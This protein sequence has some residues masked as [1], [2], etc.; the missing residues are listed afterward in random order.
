ML[1]DLLESGNCFKLVCGAGNEDANEV[2]NLIKIY[3]KAGCKF[4]DIN[5]SVE[6]L[7]TAK[8]TLKGDGY[9][10]VSIGIKGDPHIDK[11]IVDNEKCDKCNMCDCEAVFDT[12]KCIGC[13]K[14]VTRC[15]KNAI[16]LVPQEKNLEEIIPPLIKIGV[17]C[18]ELH[19]DS[20]NDRAV[21]EKW[22]YLNSVFDGMLSLCIS[23]KNLSDEKFIER[24]KHLTSIR[25]PYTTI[26]QADGIAMS[27]GCDNYKTTLQAVATAQLVKDL[28]VYLLISGGTNTKTAKLAKLCDIKY[29]GISVGSYARKIVK[30]FDEKAFLKAKALVSGKNS[31]KILDCT[32]RDGGHLCDWN[33]DKNLADEAYLSAEKSGVDYFE[34]GYRKHTGGL[35]SHCPDEILPK[36]KTKIVLMADAKDFDKNLF[37][38]GDFAVRVACHS[39]EIE[40]GIEIIEQLEGFET[41]LHLMNVD[42]IKDF[43]PLKNWQN[44]NRITSIYFADSWGTFTPDDVEYYYKKLQDLGFENISFHGHNN[45]QLAFA[46]TLKAIELGAF[47]VDATAFGIGRG[48]GNLPIELLIGHL[49]SADTKYYY[50]LIE[51]YFE[52]SPLKW[53]YSLKTL[54]SGLNNIH[55]NKIC[56]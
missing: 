12:K 50:D 9:I 48:A 8:K 24:I 15:P 45:L 38:S 51:K 34:I 13:R 56:L 11:A 47:S 20:L 23:R 54:T 52:K 25:K 4:F 29:N 35:Y 49:K 19:A 33:F 40:K 53:G 30:N 3:S 21:E 6:I 10:C 5:A 16:K 7:E 22:N 37:K 1:K 26:I 41:F 39:D 55:P 42:K 46:N 43:T 14:C 17:D 31:T 44:K 18:I 28:P 32:I 27:G 36:G 2:E